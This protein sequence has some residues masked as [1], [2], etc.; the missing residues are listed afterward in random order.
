VLGA[1]FLPAVAVLEAVLL[2]P[3]LPLCADLRSVRG[4]PRVAILGTPIL[5]TLAAT[6]AACVVPAFSVKAPERLNVEYWLDADSGR[7]QWVIRPDSGRLP[8]PMGLAAK[9]RRIDRGVFPWNLGPAF[10]SDAPYLELAA[11]TFTIL[12]SSVA[13]NKRS[14]R[15]LLRSERDAPAAAVFFPASSGIDSVRMEDFAI[16]R[17]SERLRKFLNGW[18]VYDCDTMPVRGVTLSFTLP[19]GRPVEVYAMDRTFR[20]PDEGSF[21]LKAR[22]LAATPSQDGDV[23]LVGRRI[24]LIP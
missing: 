13:D 23:T 12:E 3:L 17:P 22:P 5:T 24:Q 11:P 8:E 7:A 19:V 9:F 21:L 20:L 16:P 10:V 6:F 1:R 2:V 4:W 14:Y 18:T 15:T